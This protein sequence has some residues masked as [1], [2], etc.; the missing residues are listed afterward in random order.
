MPWNRFVL[1]YHGC[2]KALAH[3]VVAGEVKL[4]PSRN[5]YDWLGHGLYFWEDSPARALLWANAAAARVGSSV[6]VPAVLGAVIDLGNC[7]NLTE[8]EHLGA[9]ALAYRRLEAVT[10]ASGISLPENSGRERKLRRLDCAV[11]EALH[12][13]REGEG[14]PPFDTVRAYFQ[15]GEPLYPTAGIRNLDHVQICVRNPGVVKG[16]FLPR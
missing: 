12:E 1:G 3:R 11:F 9:V 15:E 6:Q 8:S 10:M 7:L 13:S 5:D 4:Q 14:P 16:Y 2:D